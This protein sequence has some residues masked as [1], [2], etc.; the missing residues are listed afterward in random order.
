MTDPPLTLQLPDR[1]AQETRGFG[2]SYKRGPHDLKVQP[3]DSALKQ[4]LQGA[5]VP[6]VL[7][8]DRGTPF[9]MFVELAFT[10]GQAGLRPQVLMVASG[11][12]TGAL[13]WHPPDLPGSRF[14][15][16]V[17]IEP[18]GY[19]VRVG[20]ETIGQGCQTFGVGPA[21]PLQAGAW[22]IPGLAGC[23]QRLAPVI[24][25]VSRQAA[26]SIPMVSLTAEYAYPMQVVVDAIGA[27]A[28]G[29]YPVTGFV[30][31]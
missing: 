12:G 8:L 30:V 15:A 25:Q 11:Q 27:I 5:H 29:G 31:H 2:S 26:H 22:D 20:G 13:A 18:N 10:L 4:H 28:Q 19:T 24:A 16:L 23:V 3:L 21:V 7:Y 14:D 17:W 9:R 6:A 1:R